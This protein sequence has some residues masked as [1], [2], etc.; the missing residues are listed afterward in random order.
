MTQRKPYPRE[1]APRVAPGTA[2]AWYDPRGEQRGRVVQNIPGPKG[3]GPTL[4]IRTAAGQQVT[5]PYRA[6]WLV[7]TQP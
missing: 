5:K 7:R 1:S 4:V 6:V 3:K 2:V